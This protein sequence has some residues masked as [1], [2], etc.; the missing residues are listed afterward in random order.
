MVED[1]VPNAANRVEISSDSAL[2]WL[3]IV[4]IYTQLGLVSCLRTEYWFYTEPAISL[5]TTYMYYST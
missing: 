4:M 3:M 5:D 1:Y 2:F